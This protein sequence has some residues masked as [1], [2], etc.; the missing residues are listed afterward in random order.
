MIGSNRFCKLVFSRMAGCPLVSGGRGVDSCQLP[1]CFYGPLYFFFFEFWTFIFSN[2][3]GC[4][5]T[6][7]GLL[8]ASRLS[9][10]FCSNLDSCQ[11][12]PTYSLSH[13]RQLAAVCRPTDAISHQA[14]HLCWQLPPLL[15][16]SPPNF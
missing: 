16:S 7:S 2:L 3:C 1:L 5:S 15:L 13:S 6:L 11:P 12:L 8:L 9:L 14:R 10:V 4:L